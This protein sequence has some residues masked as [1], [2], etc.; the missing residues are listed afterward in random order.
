VLKRA[1]IDHADTAISSDKNATTHS[2]IV[3]HPA[4]KSLGSH[5]RL[6]VQAENKKKLVLAKAAEQ[7]MEKPI[8]HAYVEHGVKAARHHS[9]STISPNGEKH[10]PI[11]VV[12]SQTQLG[13]EANQVKK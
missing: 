13:T 10:R 8:K 6:A 9:E 12:C 7:M 2:S 1:R 11:W 5:R 4:C 3:G